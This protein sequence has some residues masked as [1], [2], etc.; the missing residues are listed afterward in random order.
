MERGVLVRDIHPR[1]PKHDASATI[2]AAANA[3]TTA[4]VKEMENKNAP[5]G[6]GE[7]KASGKG[8]GKGK[9]RGKGND[10]AL[11][12]VT[13]SLNSTLIANGTANDAAVITATVTVTETVTVNQAGIPVTTVAA[14]AGGAVMDLSGANATD[15]SVLLQ[16]TETGKNKGGK[17][18]NETV[19]VATSKEVPMQH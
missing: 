13:E 17:H 10:H 18:K 2:S 11:A 1:S 7:A 4:E 6:K 8:K 15:T 9:G 16:A 19:S 14:T 12:N 5:K 3:T